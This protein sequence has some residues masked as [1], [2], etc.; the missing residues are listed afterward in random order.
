M[1]VE[2]DKSRS[3]QGTTTNPKCKPCLTTLKPW[4]TF[5]NLQQEAFSKIHHALYPP[6]ENSPQFFSPMAHMQ[7]LD[8]TI[9]RQKISSEVNLLVFH[10]FAVENFVIVI[11]TTL[12]EHPQ[13]SQ[14][15]GLG[16]GIAFE[17]Y[18]NTLSE[19]A[20]EVQAH[21]NTGH[22]PIKAVFITKGGQ[23]Y[24]AWVTRVHASA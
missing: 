12:G 3:T 1:T 23:Q 4:D 17:S 16:R 10:S 2:M 19:M 22:N 11:M 15:L 8:R 13:Y 20:E 18:T 7:E 6:N 24:L 9:K 14:N 5:L 21:T